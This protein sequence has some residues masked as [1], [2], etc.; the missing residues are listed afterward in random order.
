MILSFIVG[1]LIMPWGVCVFIPDKGDFTGSPSPFS[2]PV[3]LLIMPWEC[4]FSYLIRLTL[5]LVSNES[6]FGRCSKVSKPK[7]C[8]AFDRLVFAIPKIGLIRFM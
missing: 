5:P 8:P 1:L 2:L 3:G 6:H 4:V 7:I